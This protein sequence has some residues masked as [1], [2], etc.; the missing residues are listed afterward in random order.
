MSCRPLFVLSIGFSLW[1]L[2]KNFSSTPTPPAPPTMNRPFV[3]VF[4]CV[5]NL[6]ISFR[7]KLERVRLNQNK[8]AF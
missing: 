7:R 6:E 2:S 3:T 5:P 8:P 4:A 1:D